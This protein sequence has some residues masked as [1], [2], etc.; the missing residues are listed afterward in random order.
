MVELS[1]RLD[2]TFVQ[3]YSLREV[4][5]GFPS[6][7]KGMSIG[8]LTFLRTYSKLKEDGTKERW[9]ETVRRVV[10]GVYSIQHDYV[11]EV[12]GTEWDWLKAQASAQEM[13]NRM[14]TFKFWAPGR[15]LEN[16]G[17]EGV[18]GWGY[19]DR[20][21]NC[22]FESTAGGG[23]S[24]YGRLFSKSMRGVGVGY[25]TIGAGRDSIRKPNGSYVYVIPDSTEGWVDSTIALLDAF[26]TGS[27]EP[28]FEYGGIRKKGSIIRS[29]GVAPGSEPLRLLHERI[30]RYYRGRIGQRT[31]S[32]T[33]V[34]TCNL[35]GKAVVAGGKRR[36]ALISLGAYHDKDFANLKDFNLPENAERLDPDNGWGWASNNS[37]VLDSSDPFDF[38]EYAESVITGEPGLFF[39]DLQQN[40][41]RLIDGY[42][43]GIDPGTGTNPCGEITLE[44]GET[45]NV[46]STNPQAH[47]SMQDYLRTLKFAFLYAKSVTL[48]QTSWKHTNAVQMRN[49][50]I[51]ISMTGIAQFLEHHSLSQLT[52]WMDRGYHE[53]KHWDQVYSRWFG[54]RESIK[55]TTIKPEGTASL[56][57]GATPGVHY[58]VHSTYIRRMQFAETDPLLEVLADAG[59]TI[60]DAKGHDTTKVVELPVKGE[61]VPSE[62]DM[63][64][65]QKFAVA[66][67]AQTFWS[68]N[69]VSFTL[70]YWPGEKER[71]ATLLRTHVGE[72][73]SI[74]CDPIYADE[75]NAKEL[76]LPY[77]G[78]SD[79]QY[80][81]E[82]AKL[83]KV[84]LEYVYGN[85]EE[86]VGDKFCDGDVCVL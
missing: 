10:E 44:N 82:C 34:D 46:V 48:M 77:Q 70:K 55:L 27:P 45:C 5:W 29:G 28:Y 58:P 79:L 19:S 72:Y 66:I 11:T 54:V 37:L 7:D 75:S 76:Q 32:R 69:A 39:Q 15:G 40:Y 64:I 17:T 65:E 57:A 61:H 13:Y 78:I 83:E 85:G 24:A 26:F 47:S 49:R 23:T 3:S 86:A 43:P 35:I 1:F 38:E 2:D 51:G 71:L 20:L 60:D 42:Q 21:Y 67:L 12:T 36:T 31:S 53:I 4:T 68:D 25:D 50:R 80:E 52:R 59:Y 6:G 62:R 22:S 14:Y 8:E 30:R 9:H 41:G 33:I 18:N 81:Q 63:S 84:D 56:L 74:A 16:M 73:K